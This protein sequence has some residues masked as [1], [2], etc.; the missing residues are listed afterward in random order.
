MFKKV[1]KIQ[2]LLSCD[3]LKIQKLN[4]TIG[5]QNKIWFYSFYFDDGRKDLPYCIVK[6]KNTKKRAVFET[7]KILGF[8]YRSGVGWIPL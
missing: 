7:G 6:F 4:D 1:E 2:L 8:K 3:C 5:V